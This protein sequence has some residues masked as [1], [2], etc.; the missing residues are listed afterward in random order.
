MCVLPSC[1]FYICP[2]GLFY[3]T[4]TNYNTH[5]KIVTEGDPVL[6]HTAATLST[7]DITSAATQKLI[8]D[9][10]TALSKERFGVAIAAP[11]VG[12]SVQLF[13]VAG[14]TLARIKKTEHEEHLV[15]I[16]P[17][18]IKQSKKQRVSSEGCLSVPG[19]YGTK[20]SRADKISM[21]YLDAQ[22]QSQTYNASGFLAQIFQHEIDHLQGILY[23]DHA[24]ELIDVD[25]NMEPLETSDVSINELRKQREQDA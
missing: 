10:A 9:M 18:V 12:V 5:M 25:E 20:V 22:G 7:A 6:R 19:V 3:L 15:C 13:L 1:Q 23:I 4:H 16:N 11:Q 17:T 21:Q 24:L 2:H 14:P 8:A